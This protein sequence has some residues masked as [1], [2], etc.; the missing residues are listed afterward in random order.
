M[1]ACAMGV[2]VAAYD[3]PGIDQLI[4]H[5]KTGL[6]A[7]LGDRDALRSHWERL[8]DDRELAERLA[9]AA[10]AYVYEHYSAGRMAQEYLDLFRELEQA[11]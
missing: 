3:I 8:I 11:A 2:P 9:G 4:E 7:P 6:L 5:E 1:E 10:Q